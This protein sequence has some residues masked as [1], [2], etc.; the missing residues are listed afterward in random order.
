MK[1]CVV[2]TAR[3]L[4]A[5]GIPGHFLCLPNALDARSS[6]YLADPAL[7]RPV[8][9]SGRDRQRRKF[10]SDAAGRRHVGAYREALLRSGRGSARSSPFSPSLT[11][12]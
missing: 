2:S 4:A 7:R 9:R 1:M 6:Q 10:T 8:G 11:G 12:G 3:G 5:G